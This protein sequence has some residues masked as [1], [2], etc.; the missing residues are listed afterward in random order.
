[1]YFSCLTKKNIVCCWPVWTVDSHCVDTDLEANGENQITK[2]DWDTLEDDRMK[3]SVVEIGNFQHLG[4]DKPG[5]LWEEPF[6]PGKERGIVQGPFWSVLGVPELK[7]VCYPMQSEWSR[8]HVTGNLNYCLKRNIRTHHSF[9]G[10][11]CVIASQF[12][13]TSKSV[14]K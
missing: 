3:G 4:I 13:W 11:E 14:E 2:N 6:E 9:K 10:R 8:K 7:D 5:K 12:R 1:M